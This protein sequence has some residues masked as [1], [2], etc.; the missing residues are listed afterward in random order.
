MVLET[1]KHP[2]QLKDAV[3]SPGGTTIEVC[4]TCCAAFCGLEAMQ[5]SGSLACRS[6]AWLTSSGAVVH[7]LNLRW[8]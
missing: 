2:G 7:G 8:H 4:C 3:T 5:H 6:Y 1:G